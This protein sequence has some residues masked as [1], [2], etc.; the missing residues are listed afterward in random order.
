[1]GTTKYFDSLKTSVTMGS[2][3]VWV[4]MPSVMPCLVKM[5]WIF[6]RASGGSVSVGRCRL[7][8]QK[9]GMTLE[10]RASTDA[11]TPLASSPAADGLTPSSGSTLGAALAA[12]VRCVALAAASCAEGVDAATGLRCAGV[13]AGP[14][15]AARAPV[16]SLM[17]ARPLSALRLSRRGPRESGLPGGDGLPDGEPRRGWKLGL[18]AGASARELSLFAN[19]TAW[20]TIFCDSGRD[21]HSQKNSSSLDLT[22]SEAPAP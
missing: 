10:P 7:G 16:H 14:A 5:S 21:S 4:L 3:C 13:P 22:R 1:M 6:C 19:W 20:R 9:R 17:G 15:A 18:G 11:P 2:S 8:H 12:G